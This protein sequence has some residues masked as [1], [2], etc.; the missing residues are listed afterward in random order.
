MKKNQ[1]HHNSSNS[2]LRKLYKEASISPNTHQLKKNNINQS[3]KNLKNNAHGYESGL[4]NKMLLSSFNKQ[5]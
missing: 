4:E 3:L 1:P 5:K 2:S